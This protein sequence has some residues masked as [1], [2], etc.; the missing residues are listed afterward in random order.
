MR[1]R[2]R[3][4]L[5]EVS[6]AATPQ[7]PAE[8]QREHI[9]PMGE[10]IAIDLP[11]GANK[12]WVTRVLPE[13]L[14]KQVEGMTGPSA[15]EALSTLS[16][17]RNGTAYPLIWGMPDCLGPAKNL[18]EIDNVFLR[19]WPEGAE[20]ARK[21][22]DDVGTE[23]PPAQSTRRRRIVGKEGTDP[24]VE[25]WLDRDLDH[26]WERRHKVTAQGHKIIQIALGWGG[27]AHMTGDSLF[28]AGAAALVLTEML[29]AAGYGVEVHAYSY[30]G[31]GWGQA[32]GGAM[33]TDCVVKPSDQPIS[34]DT[35]AGVIA[36]AGSWRSYGLLRIGHAP[37]NFGSSLGRCYDIDSVATPLVEAGIIP[38]IE[39]LLP[40]LYSREKAL[41]AIRRGL[42]DVADKYGEQA[43][44]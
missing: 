27:N 40:N 14:P 25:A 34:A 30:I 5:P 11:H 20:R 3:L 24:I 17:I 36:H 19:G 32:H 15:K 41:E 23:V 21:L 4:R 44:W 28:W 22:A 1:R 9:P 13:D 8:P 38:E 35:F 26:L 29:E 18:A 43:Q 10:V 6:L 2:R 7:V 16:C 33:L 39:I 37:W 31:V 42:Q 12:L